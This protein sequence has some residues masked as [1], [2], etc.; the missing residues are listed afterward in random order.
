MIPLYFHPGIG[1]TATTTLQ[2][3]VFSKHSEILYIGKD[4]TTRENRR[5]RG[6]TSDEF[7]TPFTSILKQRPSAQPNV[8]EARLA[9]ENS[10]RESGLRK[11]AL[12]SW[13]GSATSKPTNFQQIVDNLCAVTP[14]V[15][16]LFTIRNQLPWL[17][18]SYLQWIA[19]NFEGENVHK[20]TTPFAQFDEWLLSQQTH[21][22]KQPL[23]P[24]Y[25]NIDYA[26][27]KVGSQN[28]GIFCFEELIQNPAQFY[29][30]IADFLGVD[31]TEFIQL[32]STHHEN[33]RITQSQLDLART[34]NRSFLRRWQ[35]RFSSRKRNRALFNAARQGDKP[36]VVISE[37]LRNQIIEQSREANRNFANKYKI[38]LAGFGYPM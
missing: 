29:R 24:T 3:S 25:D 17:K 28:V 14:N 36:K 7:Y 22:W 9:L 11:I 1:K 38:D 4:R 12:A 31:S 19:G 15:K 2:K 33:K 37:P 21:R 5:R 8:K 20:R 23:P 27:A 35:W 34:S 18:S 6:Y 16:I 10:I 32:A 26:V 30:G 13:E